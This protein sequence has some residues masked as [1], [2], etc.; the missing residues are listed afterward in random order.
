MCLVA[1]TAERFFRIDRALE[2]L[3]YVSDICSSD[4]YIVDPDFQTVNCQLQSQTPVGI[5]SA[6]PAP[7]DL[8]LVSIRPREV[9]AV[10]SFGSMLF[11]CCYSSISKSIT[12]SWAYTTVYCHTVPYERFFFDAW[13]LAG[14]QQNNKIAVLM[15]RLINACSNKMRPPSLPPSV[16]VGICVLGLRN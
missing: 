9:T 11:S 12:T 16:C 4:L 10:A 14:H 5:V 6:S 8:P 15:T 13:L 2:Q 1:T 3:H 7:S